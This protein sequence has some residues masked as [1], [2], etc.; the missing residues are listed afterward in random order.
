MFRLLRKSI[1]LVTLALSSASI[2]EN[3][4]EYNYGIVND[5]PSSSYENTMDIRFTCEY[6]SSEI[7][8]ILASRKKK[9][10]CHQACKQDPK[11]S[12][13]HFDHKHEIC[14]AYQAS[15]A[16]QDTHIQRCAQTNAIL[17]D[18]NNFSCRLGKTKSF[19]DISSI[20]QC[21]EKCLR[22][23]TCYGFEYNEDAEGCDLF[24]VSRLKTEVLCHKRESIVGSLKCPCFSDDEVTKA[25]RDLVDGIKTSNLQKKSCHEDS[26]GLYGLYYTND[27]PLPADRIFNSFAVEKGKCKKDNNPMIIARE[28]KDVCRSHLK[29][30]C[31][32]LEDKKV[33]LDGKCACFTEEHINNAV[34]SLRKGSKIVKQGACEKEKGSG[35]SISL[36]YHIKGYENMIEGY[37]VH[38]S[39]SSRKCTYGGDIKLKNISAQ[40]AAHCS[41]LIR[42]ACGLLK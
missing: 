13:Y 20:D 24:I 14:T 40:S 17:D 35:H 42:D 25:T 28:E 27:V 39:Q 2:E 18:D 22:A 19:D 30:S 15:S 23:R 29:D 36:F 9:K 1:I 11:C 7:V 21:R 10:K 41:F 3:S 31:K 5:S 6:V 37:N 33:S 12:Y 26:S 38:I 4:E 32:V 8:K 34:E 16:L